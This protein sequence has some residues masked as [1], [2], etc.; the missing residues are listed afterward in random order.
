MHA[1][2]SRMT[3]AEFITRELAAEIAQVSETTIDRWARAGRLTKYKVPGRVST[4]YRRADLMAIL[5]PAPV[6]VDE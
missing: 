3:D 6:S 5:A 1:M 4:R 2:F